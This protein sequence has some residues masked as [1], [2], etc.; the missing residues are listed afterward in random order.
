MRAVAIA[1]FGA[2]TVAALFHVYW[3]FGGLWP[4]RTELELIQS[5]VGDPGLREMYDRD[6]TLMVASLIFLAGAAALFGGAIIPGPP[7]WM[8]RLT[9]GF[10]A[11]VF[12]A[13]GALGYV[14][15][16]VDAPQTEPF[17]TYNLWFYSPLCL[18]IGIGFVALTVWRPPARA[19]SETTGDAA[20]SEPID[21]AEEAPPW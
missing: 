20:F 12:F 7:R 5:V 21:A 2:L 18:A 6:V 4:G 17:E 10:L 19:P 15:T 1:V 8:V 16:A 14:L 3:A 11:A 9:T 13:R